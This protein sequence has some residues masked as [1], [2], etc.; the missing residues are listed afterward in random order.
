M[1]M[2]RRKNSLPIDAI[3]SHLTSTQDEPEIEADC[4]TAGI[5][6]QEASNLPPSWPTW[7]AAVPNWPANTRA[8]SVRRSRCWIRKCCRSGRGPKPPRCRCASLWFW[9]Q[10][11][12][13][14]T[15]RVRW[16]GFGS[17]RPGCASTPDSVRCFAAAVI[18]FCCSAELQFG[19]ITV[20]RLRNSPHG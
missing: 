15:H 11:V 2:H 12:L 3:V 20:L 8:H 14:P 5:G 13:H 9:R 16:F 7:R 6:D 1:A 17:C 18:R 10:W 19:P 4:R